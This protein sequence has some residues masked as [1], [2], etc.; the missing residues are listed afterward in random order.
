MQTLPNALR[1]LFVVFWI[2]GLWVIGLL[3]A[4]VLFHEAESA[5]AGRIAG[6]LFRDMAWV[7]IV[8]GLYI[9]LHMLWVEGLR[10]VQTL[11]FWLILGMFAL[12]LLNQFA[13]FPILAQAKSQ[14]HSAAEGVFGGGFQSWHAI[15]SLIYLV[16]SLLGL[17]YVVRGSVK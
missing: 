12:T 5:F 9:L 8:A 13:V 14:V 15:S 6:L 3:V 10:A 17:F 4:P 1:S 2:G 7:G 11:E 16:Q